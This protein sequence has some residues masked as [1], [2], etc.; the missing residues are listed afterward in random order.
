MAL[1]R[2]L[3]DSFYGPCRYSTVLGDSL[4]RRDS[5]KQSAA[6]GDTGVLR[7][8]YGYRKHFQQDSGLRTVCCVSLA[9]QSLRRGTLSLIS[10]LHTIQISPMPSCCWGFPVPLKP[11]SSCKTLTTVLLDREGA[12]S[13]FREMLGVG[14]RNVTPLLTRLRD[15][16]RTAEAV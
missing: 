5:W 10:L 16:Y 8:A 9:S 4:T 6:Q 11:G 3:L 15:I 1:L 13:H 14:Q 12:L 2:S 7:S